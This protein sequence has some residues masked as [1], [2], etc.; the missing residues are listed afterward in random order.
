MYTSRGKS[1]ISPHV[2]NIFCVQTEINKILRM[3]YRSDLFLC[4]FET[5]DKNKCMRGTDKQA[6]RYLQKFYNFQQFSLFIVP[7]KA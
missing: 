7:H 5:I 6:F 4:H 3:F 2:D 1:A